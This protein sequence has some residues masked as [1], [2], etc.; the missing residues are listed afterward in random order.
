[1]YVNASLKNSRDNF[2]Y[3]DSKQTYCIFKAC[4]MMFYLAQ[5]DIYFIFLFVFR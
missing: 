1:M 2:I 3:L 5:S 4:C